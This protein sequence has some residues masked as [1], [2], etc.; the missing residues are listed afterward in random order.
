MSTRMN[1]LLQRAGKAA[2]RFLLAPDALSPAKRVAAFGVALYIWAI[3]FI[4]VYASMGAPISATIIAAG[5]AVL[6]AV[7]CALRWGLSPNICGNLVT[8]AAF[9]VYTALALVNGGMTGP[10][11]NWYASIPVLAILLS[12]TRAGTFWTLLSVIAIEFFSGSREFGYSFPNEVTPNCFRLL[13]FAGMVG[14]VSCIFMLVCA[15][16]S[17]EENA[18]RALHQANECLEM[19]ASTDPLTGICNRRS[20]DKRLE[21]EWRRHERSNQPLS[22]LLID[23]DYFKQYNDLFGHLVG[24]QCLKSI[25]KIIHALARRPGDIAARFGGE[26]FAIVLCNTDSRA[27]LAFAE[28]LRIQ[29]KNLGIDHPRSLIGPRLTISIGAATAIPSETDS[30]VDLICRADSALYYAKANGRDQA[31]QFTPELAD[32]LA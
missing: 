20:F 3:V 8:A 15:L 10:S 9:Y 29:V 24:D 19:L 30:R 25:A 5:A 6:T 12:G 22:A 14:L 17:V 4:F 26:E 27:A 28:N 23:I 1:R 16:K 18:Q 13:Q 32:A 11:V 7:L 21:Q 31:I 2:C